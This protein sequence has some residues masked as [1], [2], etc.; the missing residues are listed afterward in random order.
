MK[1]YF[2]VDIALRKSGLVVVDETGKMVMRDTLV[3]PA[4]DDLTAAVLK[5]YEKLLTVLGT[6]PDGD[7]IYVIEDVAGFVHIKAALGI[8]AGRTAA[9]LAYHHSHISNKAIEY[10]TPNDVKLWIAGKRSASKE[11]V[12]AGMKLRFPE[13]PYSVMSEDEIDALA[14]CLYSIHGSKNAKSVPSTKRRKAP[15]RT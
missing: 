10:H 4:K 8:H 15:R 11:E 5:I 7:L 6:I 9:I 14:L 2:G 12:L 1:Y 13:Y 3:V